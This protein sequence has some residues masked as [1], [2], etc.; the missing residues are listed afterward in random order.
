MVNYVIYSLMCRP[1][2]LKP[3]VVT[4]KF[5]CQLYRY[6]ESRP[7]LKEQNRKRESSEMLRKAENQE[8]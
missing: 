5:D 2:K 7:V 8:S 6:S 1:I 3:D 4:H